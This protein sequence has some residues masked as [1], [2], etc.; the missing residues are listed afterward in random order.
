LI[1]DDEDEG[2]ASSECLVLCTLENAIYDPLLQN[3]AH[4]RKS[5]QQWQV[6]GEY[7]AFILR[8]DIVF[9]QLV[10]QITGVGRPR[11]SKSAIL[12]LQIPLPPLPV[13]REIVSAYKMAWKHYLECRNRSQVALREGD[14]TLS[15][16][17]ARA[18]EKLCPTSR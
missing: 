3:I 11:A 13:Q 15:A 12:G 9:G 7:L 18:S 17:Y 14:E 2:F 4:K 5:L 1:R 10:Y 6:I 16:A 8:S